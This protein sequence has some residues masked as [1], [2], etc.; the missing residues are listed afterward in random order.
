MGNPAKTILLIILLLIIIL[1][2]FALTGIDLRQPEKA[3]YTLVDKVLELNRAINR[4]V[5]QF[6]YSIRLKLK[7]TF[8][9]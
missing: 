8:S 5:R 1:V 4:A 7:D 9:R 3:A 6:F 2:F